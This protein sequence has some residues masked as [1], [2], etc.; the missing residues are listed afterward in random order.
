M[1]RI[2]TQLDD[3]DVDELDAAASESGTSRAAVLRTLVAQWRWERRRARDL[4]AVASSYRE[5]PPEDDWL[6]PTEAQQWPAT[7]ERGS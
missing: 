3:A 1:K 5:H 6:F 4:E 2:I 7:D